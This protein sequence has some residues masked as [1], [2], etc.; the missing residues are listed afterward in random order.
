MDICL[1]LLDG[2]TNENGT[3]LTKIT[4]ITV[5]E[6]SEHIIASAP[7]KVVMG[8]SGLFII[9]INLMLII[10]LKKTNTKLSM[11]QKLY[12]YLSFADWQVG[13]YLLHVLVYYTLS[14]SGVFIGC[15][16]IKPLMLNIHATYCIGMGTFIAISYLRNIAIRKPFHV[17]KNRTVYTLFF[18]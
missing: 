5:A 15:G 17:V 12:I 10:G 3:N 13:I 6:E 14:S 8:A 7:V 18:L 2:S 1:P 4:N 16:D 11:S 9:T